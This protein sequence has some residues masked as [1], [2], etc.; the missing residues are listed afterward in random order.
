METRDYCR[1]QRGQRV[2]SVER[3]RR[4]GGEK[5]AGEV[6]R[7]WPRRRSG[8][9]GSGRHRVQDSPVSLEMQRSG[10]W[11]W[12]KTARENGALTRVLGRCCS[13]QMVL[14]QVLSTKV[15]WWKGVRHAGINWIGLGAG[16]GAQRGRALMSF[17]GATRRIGRAKMG[18]GERWRGE[19]RG[20][21]GREE[22]DEGRPWCVFFS[23]QPK[24]RQRQGCRA[25]A[26]GAGEQL[27]RRCRATTLSGCHHV[28]VQDGTPGQDS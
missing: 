6:G 12:Q 4:G 18:D 20:G 14:R 8:A 9:S 3:K 21:G 7:R 13:W 1:R 15:C 17:R 2:K 22:G 26:A 23:F 25:A 16:P 10:R 5:P 11:R 19:G 24:G 28:L 27:P